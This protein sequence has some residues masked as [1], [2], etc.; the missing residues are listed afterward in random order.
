MAEE[1]QAK[2]II[3]TLTGPWEM[4]HLP[5]MAAALPK[6]VVPDHL[7]VLGILAAFVIGIGYA[8]TR[9]SPQWL[10]LSNFGL[11]LHW[12]A[13]SLDGTLARVRHIE[14]ERYGYFVDHITDAFSV[15]IICLGL[16][17]SPLMDLRVAMLLAVGY[18]LLNIYAHVAAYTRELFI[19]SYA[20]IGPTEVRIF[21]FLA[22]LVL[23]FWNPEVGEIFN[24][25]LTAVD[26]AGLVITIIFISLFIILAIK[27]AIKLDRLDRAKTRNN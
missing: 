4:R 2:R 5:K 13:D 24:V 16:G 9:Y 18:L 27:D 25:S 21:I 23:M 22:N 14:R 7:T 1:H 11:F 6:W 3:K 19:L 15:F 17:A 26:L 8:L 10:W 12:Y 20:K